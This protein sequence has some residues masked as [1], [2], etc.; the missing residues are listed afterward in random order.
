MAFEKK[1]L[2]L[3]FQI[4]VGGISMHAWAL[5]VLPNLLYNNRVEVVNE[6]S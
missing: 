6:D 2:G 4:P 1:F 3:A 5:G